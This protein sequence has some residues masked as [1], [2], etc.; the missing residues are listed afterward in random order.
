MLDFLSSLWDFYID[1]TLGGLRATAVVLGIGAVISGI[2]WLRSRAKEKR[3]RAAIEREKQQRG[4]GN[5]SVCVR[6]EEDVNK[7]S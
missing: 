3:L 7:T 6:R 5:V 4:M 1:Y 2:G